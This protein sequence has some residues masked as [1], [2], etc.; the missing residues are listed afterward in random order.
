MAGLLANGAPTTVPGGAGRATCTKVASASPGAARWPGVV[1]P[2]T[3]TERMTLTMDIFATACAAAGVVLRRTLTASVFCRA[4]WRTVAGWSSRV[5]FR[6]PCEG[7]P[8]YGGKTI[9]AFRRDDWKL[10]QDGPF[11]PLELYNLK[12]D[13]QETTDLAA[14]N[15]RIFIDLSTEGA[16]KQIQ[17]AGSVPWQSPKQSP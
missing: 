8:A 12:S 10:L 5:L 1:A 17:R 16:C 11:K 4:A 14:K 13:P 15:E 3:S 9:D 6:P 2:G 7:G